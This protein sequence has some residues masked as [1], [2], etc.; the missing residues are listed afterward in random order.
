MAGTNFVGSLPRF[1][2]DH[3][4]MLPETQKIIIL[5]QPTLRNKPARHLFGV[6][7]KFSFRM[8]YKSGAPSCVINTNEALRVGNYF[9]CFELVNEPDEMSL[10]DNLGGPS[11]SHIHEYRY[12]VDIEATRRW[13][14]D[15]PYVNLDRDSDSIGGSSW[16]G[17]LVS[18]FGCAFSTRMHFGRQAG[19][20]PEE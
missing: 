20:F 11:R 9:L 2:V 18:W 8:L 19:L 7:S 17:N 12:H 10:R 6:D 1:M 13:R 16:D 4:R 14:N 3:M 5:N 15:P